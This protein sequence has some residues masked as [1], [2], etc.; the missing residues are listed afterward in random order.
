MPL[1][2]R[3]PTE[4]VSLTDRLGDLGRTRRRVLVVRG[5]FRVLA[6][7]A[8]L[9]AAAC[10][11]DVA[12][13]LPGIVRAVLLVGTLAAVGVVFLRG[14]AKSVR[15]PVHPLAIALMLEEQF[16]RLNDA[17][18]SAV[19]FLTHADR[20][21][22][23]GR[24]TVAR[25]E[26]LA[27]KHDLD[28]I[29]PAGKAWRAFWLATCVVAAAAALALTD[30]AR[31]RTAL[32]R[33]ADPF[34]KHP[35]PAKTL[36]EL[37][38]PVPTRLAKG[39]PFD[40]RFA[41]RG[42]VPD[43]AVLFVR[44]PGT[45]PAEEVIPLAASEANPAECVADV[46]LDPARVAKD[47]EFRVTANDADT[48][49]H[50]VAVSPA[51]KLVPLDGRPSPQVSLVFPGYTDLRPATLPDGTGVVECVAGTRVTF[52]AAADQRVTG[53]VFH[54]QG[55]LGP[56]HVAAALAT[57]VGVNPVSPLAARELAADATADIP[58]R[59][60]GPDGTRLEATFVPRLPGLYA[61]R[62]TG[63]DGLTGTR[64]FSF[65]VFPDPAPA[66]GLTRP[67]PA[68]DPLTLLP[69]ASI[70]VDVRAEDRTFAVRNL[71]LEYRI[72]GP[73][74]E[75]RTLPLA[76]L[77]AAARTLAAA[78]GPGPLVAVE[79][80]VA[81]DATRSV[82]L[83][84]FTRPDGTPPADGDVIT[85]R[86]AS[87]DWDDYNPTKEPGRSREVE[88]RV[89]GK[90]SFDAML[91]KELAGLRPEL[92]RLREEQ[93]LNREAVADLQKQAKDAV[94]PDSPAKLATA[95]Q[96][97]RQIRNQVADPADGLRAKA[98]RLKQ[99]VKANGLPR[100]PTTDRVDGVAG[101]LNRLADQH[102]EA[103]EPQVALARQEA[104]KANA[105]QK[106]DPKKLNELLAKAA[107]TQ[108]AAEAEL[109]AVLERL[110][111]WGGAGEIRGAARDLKDKIHKTAEENARGLEKLPAKPADDL[112][113]AQKAALA[114]A[115]DK[116]D[117]L[118]EQAGG[119][120][121]K[122]TRLAAE[123]AAQAEGIRRAA[124]ARRADAEAVEQEAAAAPK[125]SQKADRLRD[126]A[127]DLKAE[128]A[129]LDRAADRAK[130]EA[131]TLRKA[132]SD[133]GGQAVPEDLRTAANALR[134]NKP[135]QSA[136]S[137][138]SAA[139]RLDKLTAGLGEKPAASG[140]E[141]AKK[142][143]ENADTLDKL[144]ADQ[145]ELRKKAKAA[146][147]EPDADKRAEQLRQLAKDQDQLRRRAAALAEKLTRDKADP[148]A[149][150]VR[151]AANEMAAAQD[152]LE[153]GKSPVP[154][155]D[156]ALQK[157]DEALDKLE[158]EQK[159][160]ADELSREKREQLADQLK[161]LRDRQQAAGAEAVR[162]GQAAVKGKGW[163][164]PLLASLTDFEDRQKNLAG[165]L[166][167]FAGKK[168]A[169]LPVFGK[170]A[171][172]AAAAMDRAARTASERK[173]DALA[174][175]GAAFD[176]E[177]DRAAH[178]RVLRPTRTALRRLD[179]ILDSLK[180]EPKPNAAKPP[181]PNAGGDGNQPKPDDT[182]AGPPQDGVPKLAQLKALRA[183]QAELNDQTAAFDK[184]HPDPAK[185][186]D[187][188]KDELKEL[189]QTQREIAEL[190]DK[191]A[192]ALRPGE[193]QP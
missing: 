81:L 58:V 175:A 152:K 2:L 50:A 77:T 27:N 23:F 14:V 141:L 129:A 187:D 167:G 102:L 38:G 143:K 56:A 183:V 158:A 68:R 22:R 7:A 33:L 1:V 94:P 182:Q 37:R 128:A 115:A 130:L 82:P 100:S 87:R 160:A 55:D 116:L 17:L 70:P 65:Q 176:P 126:R 153:D 44:H 42:V 75:F 109:D 98:D 179:Q 11:L 162:I 84:A 74:S 24:I 3:P 69:T 5:A 99:A 131:D 111:Q 10:A 53:A 150:A 93:R 45:A 121:A 189:E 34:G 151:R 86:A 63:E 170:L 119:V 146:A 28:R 190:F 88:I 171:E 138:K 181:D 164:R 142:Q 6:A 178:E 32:V 166:R 127:A 78:A 148:S 62:L 80:P 169:D 125:D 12:V 15:E 66:V 123:K 193:P 49:W 104:D 110:E 155:Q 118:G 73:G 92:L 112:T 61:L 133:A 174:D 79:R 51:P 35:W 184:A 90:A 19:D 47:F 154:Q 113:P 157:F 40:L 147:A 25:A 108:R 139:D 185:L 159:K 48:G 168:L 105:G 41:V 13:H 20:S 31:T 165:E 191:L 96:S 71:V 180:D 106:P 122:A 186:T 172:Q 124:A 4:R 107:S 156:D 161:A 60:S 18:A 76:D 136:A 192:P 177:A 137:Q 54:P 140:D 91:Q 43:R 67:D 114:A 46:R 145:D 132:V 95:E 39:E 188:E 72:V 163:S 29:V 144:A 83:A 36:V 57:L 120:V 30:T 135:G 134:D 16:P 101:D 85:V 21:S 117:Q 52:R 9:V 64:L 103:A 97:Q 8:V 89:L 173:D 59:V 26:N 149:D